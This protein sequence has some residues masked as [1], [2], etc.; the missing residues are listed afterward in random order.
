MRS[1]VF[2][3]VALAVVAIACAVWSSGSGSV[4]S[5]RDPSK[6]IPWVCVV[7]DAVAS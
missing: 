3:G 5:R 4:I 6:P 1:S 2:G 7:A